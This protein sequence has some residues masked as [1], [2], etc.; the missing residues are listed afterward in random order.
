MESA[1]LTP[2]LLWVK[3]KVGW[4]LSDNLYNTSDE[5]KTWHKVSLPDKRLWTIN[6][7]CF[8]SE[9]IGWIAGEDEA[10]FET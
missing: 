2:D 6:S 3:P 8:I 4:V 1:M 9:N 7:F 10:I 5:G